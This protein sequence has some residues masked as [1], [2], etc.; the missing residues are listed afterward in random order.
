MTGYLAFEATWRGQFWLPGQSGQGDRQGLLTYKP[1]AG[2]TL[3]LIG[4]FDDGSTARLSCGAVAL[5]EGS[6]RFAVIHGV[7][8]GK[9]VTL[10]DCL[11]TRSKSRGFLPQV[12]EQEIHAEDALMGVVLDDADARAF[13]GLTI[14]LENLTAWDPRED[15]M[16]HI[17]R[18]PEVNHGRR[19]QVAVDPVEPLT[20]TVDDLTI[21]LGRRYALPSSDMQRDGLDVSTFTASYLT[22]TSPEPRSI[23]EWDEIAKVFQDLLTLAIDSPC[24]VLSETLA[25]SDAL[26]NDQAARARDEI[27]RYAQHVIAADPGAP[28]VPARKAFFTLATEGIDFRTVIPR[29]LE[30]NSKFKVACDMILS[31]RYAQGVYLQTELITAVGAAEATHEGLGFDPPM[32]NSEFKE[33]KKTLLEYVPKNH[34]AWLREKLGHNTRTLRTKLLDLAATP[35]PEMISA[36]LPNPDAWAKATKTERD[37][38]AH[39]GKKMSR[40]AELLNAITKVTTAVVLVNLLHQLG[41]PKDRLTF[42]MVDNPSLSGAARLAREH[43]PAANDVG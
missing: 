19:W 11:V 30:V 17:D 21:E 33:L 20:V 42:A 6:G 15:I 10:L 28:S 35:D 8:G 1:E 40:D 3:S 27:L 34:R 9:P 7:A 18:N 43:W 39:G 41:V 14:E 5:R 25:P 16:V 4:G 13:C 38:V 24:A 31:L 2:I 23:A 12:E 32:P 26:R 22:I 29:W 37:P 36:L